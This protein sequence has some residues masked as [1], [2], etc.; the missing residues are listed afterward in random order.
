[1]VS[2]VSKT[3]SLGGVVQWGL[4]GGSAMMDARRVV[5]LSGVVVASTTRLARSIP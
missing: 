1:V 4:G 2:S 3:T 5:A